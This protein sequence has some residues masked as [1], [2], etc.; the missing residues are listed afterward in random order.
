MESEA[1]KNGS[2]AYLLKKWGPRGE[3]GRKEMRREV[4]VARRRER[5]GEGM[6]EGGAGR[7]S[8]VFNFFCC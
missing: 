2:A 8:D 5:R 6:D 1:I 4:V 7:Q 3:E